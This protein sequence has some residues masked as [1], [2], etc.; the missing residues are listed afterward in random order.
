MS[1]PLVRIDA[2]VSYPGFGSL[3]LDD[4]EVDDENVVGTASFPHPVGD[5][6]HRENVTMN[7][8]LTCVRKWDIR[9][10]PD[11]NHFPED[12]SKMFPPE[13][14]APE[15]EHYAE[16]TITVPIESRDHKARAELLDAVMN[17]G[18]IPDDA[19]GSI[20]LAPPDPTPSSDSL[21]K[22]LYRFDPFHDKSYPDTPEDEGPPSRYEV[23]AIDTGI[24]EW[25]WAE[26]GEWVKAAD[27]L[28][29]LTDLEH[30]LQAAHRERNAAIEKCGEYAEQAESAEHRLQEAEYAVQCVQADAD[31]GAARAEAA[32]ALA[33][34]RGEVIRR[35]HRALENTEPG[36]WADDAIQVLWSALSDAP[37]T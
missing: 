20:R 23:E 35:A 7:F 5:G 25:R 2:L 27:A 3:W 11:P 9:T 18:E 10:V 13:P 8:P 32:E 19:V 15:G 21:E 4:C 6:F 29:R 12:F 36:R 37:D 26:D 16:I 1:E 34:R 22:Q 17:R 28:P 30:R 24:V 31:E 14:Q 33:A